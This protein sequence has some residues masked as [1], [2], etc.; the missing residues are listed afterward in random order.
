MMEYIYNKDEF[1]T[2]AKCPMCADYCPVPD[3]KGICKYE[4]REEVEYKLT[5]KGCLLA[6]LINHGIRLDDV[7]IELV[8]ADF[9]D[10]MKRMD[11]VKE[12]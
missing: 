12:E 10:T 1:C 11:Y 2:N 6:A 4:E 9:E 7:T 8:W 3:T 5:P